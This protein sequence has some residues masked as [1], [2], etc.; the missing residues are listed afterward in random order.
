MMKL[1][2]FSH[3]LTS[4]QL[5]QITDIIK[6]TVSVVAEINPQFDVEQAFAPQVADLLDSLNIQ[7]PAWQLETWLIVLPALNTIASVLLAELHAR[8]GHFPSIVRLCPT[9]H[10]F[11]THYIVAEIVD[12][13]RVRQNARMRR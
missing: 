11:S 1:I 5:A 8:M 9:H 6:T 13:E 2:N 10:N 4:E 7:T 3:P 12:L